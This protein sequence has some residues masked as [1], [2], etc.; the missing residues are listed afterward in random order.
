[1][2]CLCSCMFSSLAVQ[3]YCKLHDKKNGLDIYKSNFG[4]FSVSKTFPCPICDNYESSE[5]INIILEN[6]PNKLYKLNEEVFRLIVNYEIVDIFERL[7]IIE[8]QKEDILNTFNEKRYYKHTCK[9]KKVSCYIIIYDEKTYKI[10]DIFYIDEKYKYSEWKNNEY[11]KNSLLNERQKK[12]E[13][14]QK[15]KA[16]KQKEEKIQKIKDEWNEITFKREEDVYNKALQIV[17]KKIKYY[18]SI[19]RES[20]FGNTMDL[21]DIYDF[22]K[23]YF[24]YLS[25]KWRIM[26]YISKY[27]KLFQFAKDFLIF[28][29]K[30][31]QSEKEEY[32]QFYNEKIK[33]IDLENEIV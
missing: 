29:P 14:L 9:K 13:E 17:E 28:E 32:T 24:K 15:K 25:G 4:K 31:T 5:E 6:G 23:D 19:P 18:S 20:E 10:S 22:V 30:M 7:E 27:A 3:H 33:N 12:Y 1:M 8:K 2:G 11:I 26:Q 21:L 16:E